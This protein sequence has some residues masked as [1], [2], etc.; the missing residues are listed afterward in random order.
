MTLQIDLQD[1]FQNDTVIITAGS[2]RVYE[3]SGVTTDLTISRADGFE[4]EVTEPVTI[5]VR[6]PARQAA[7]AEAVNPAE[8]P[9]VAISVQSDG[10]I[11]FQKSMSPFLYM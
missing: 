10:S 11:R 9:F 4:I 8:T 2:R 1:G 7:A 5:S 6:I 3:K